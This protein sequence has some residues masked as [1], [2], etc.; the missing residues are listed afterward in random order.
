MH[1]HLDQKWRELFQVTMKRVQGC[2][3][4]LEISC[5][6]RASLDFGSNN[7]VVAKLQLEVRK[8]TTEDFTRA[9]AQSSF[10]VELQYLATAICFRQLRLGTLLCACAL[11]AT[12][13]FAYLCTETHTVAL[14]GEAA[15]DGSQFIFGNMSEIMVE[16]DVKSRVATHRAI[17]DSN[18]KNVPQSIQNVATLMYSL[19]SCAQMQTL[20]TRRFDPRQRI[21]HKT[22]CTCH[23]S[24]IAKSAH[25]HYQTDVRTDLN[26]EYKTSTVQTLLSFHTVCFH[27]ARC[28]LRA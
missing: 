21:T 7:H 16:P 24:T 28:V 26:T 9:K 27:A 13:Q 6:G 17:V 5:V 3:Y 1:G 20:C 14:Q 11:L 12:Q 19:Y 18:Q 22:N 4:L 2:F 8:P 15:S 23:A 25:C 10:Y